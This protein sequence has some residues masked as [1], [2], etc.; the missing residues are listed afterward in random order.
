MRKHLSQ[1][2]AT[3]RTH[4][5]LIALVCVN[6]VILAAWLWSRDGQTTVLRVEVI[7]DHFLATIDGNVLIDRDVD[8]PATGGIELLL[9][10]VALPSLRGSR[11]FDRITVKDSAN[12][13]VLFEDHFSDLEATMAAWSKT[14]RV[15]IDDGLLQAT[16]FTTVLAAGDQRRREDLDVIERLRCSVTSMRKV[17]FRTPDSSSRSASSLLTRAALSKWC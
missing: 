17:S 13:R 14:E 10:P 11:G 4:P 7:G 12:G 1:L 6:V 15:S 9:D 3:L 16:K 2:P 5:W 8:A